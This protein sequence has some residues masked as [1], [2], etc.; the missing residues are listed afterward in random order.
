MYV[1][2]L[3]ARFEPCTSM[4]TNQNLTIIL[5][6]HTLCKCRFNIYNTYFHAYFLGIKKATHAHLACM[7]T[8][9][10]SMI[11]KKRM[12]K[13]THDRKSKKSIIRKSMKSIFR[14]SMDCYVLSLSHHYIRMG[15]TM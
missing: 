9:R 12:I 13:I 2:C 5:T 1:T 14:K 8:F 15:S 7:I 4:L 11:E 10:K 6:Y 3:G